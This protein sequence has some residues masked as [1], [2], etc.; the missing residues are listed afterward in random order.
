M[1]GLPKK[2]CL[3]SC[4][5]DERICNHSSTGCVGGYTTDVSGTARVSVEVAKRC[6][7][8]INLGRRTLQQANWSCS[9]FA[10]DIQNKQ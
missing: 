4:A 9:L 8:D 6:S 1:G 3:R 2:A 7:S 5:L 10:I